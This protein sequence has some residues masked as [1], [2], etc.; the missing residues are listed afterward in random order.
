MNDWNKIYDLSLGSTIQID[1]VT[2]RKVPTGW[3]FSEHYGNNRTTT[4]VPDHQP[5]VL[6]VGTSGE[7]GPG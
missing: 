3:I 6:R 4:F 7:T 5:V 2:I 1:M